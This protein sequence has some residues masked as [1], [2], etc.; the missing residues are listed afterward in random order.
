[1]LRTSKYQ[2][3]IQGMLSGYEPNEL[4]RDL[5]LALT[6]KLGTTA[7]L[8]ND[9]I[10][11]D[12]SRQTNKKAIR[13]RSNFKLPHLIVPAGITRSQTSQITPGCFQISKNAQITSLLDALLVSKPARGYS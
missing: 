5:P 13:E 9:P 10:A 3:E 2:H 12:K 4:Y 1:M 6:K 11:L 8:G 7:F